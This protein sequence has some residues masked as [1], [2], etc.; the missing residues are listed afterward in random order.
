PIGILI[1]ITDMIIVHFIAVKK[2][3]PKKIIKVSF[4]E[5]IKIFGNGI[6]ALILPIIILGGILS[7]VFTPTEAAAVAVGY[8]FFAGFL[9]LK[10]LKFSHLPKIF[11]NAAVTTGVVFLLLASARLYSWVLSTYR[12][13]YLIQ[14]GILS[15]S[16]NPYIVIFLINLILLGI[17][18]VM[19]PGA[20][21]IMLAPALAPLAWQVGV[22]PIQFG[23][24]MI[25]NLCL[26]LIT[27]PVGL[28]LFLS[29]DIA[30]TSLEKVARAVMPMFFLDLSVLFLVSYC[31][32][33]VLFVPRLLGFA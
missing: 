24:I 10:T 23:M 20:A 8:A 30:K 14:S 3:Y 7:G 22:H 17:G 26:G 32:P 21:I 2:N 4:K 19:D 16:S 1:G 6:I 5:F 15:I 33:F 9:L 29:A 25:V 27:P 18:C 12:V 31:Q 28:C 11:I 13:P